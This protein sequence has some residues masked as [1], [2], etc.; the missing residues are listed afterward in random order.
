MQ[1]EQKQVPADRSDALQSC[2]FSSLQQAD[3]LDPFQEL[4]EEQRYPVATPS[5]KHHK[6]PACKESKKELI[7]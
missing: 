4:L 5:P 2:Y 7:T 1:F 3:E 6:Y